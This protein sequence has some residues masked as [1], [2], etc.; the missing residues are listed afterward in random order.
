MEVTPETP[1]PA[2]SRRSSVEPS[3]QKQTPQDSNREALRRAHRTFPVRARAEAQQAVHSGS[4]QRF[5][6]QHVANHGLATVSRSTDNKVLARV[7]DSKLFERSA[8]NWTQ[9]ST[10]G[11]SINN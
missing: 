11:Q 1:I 2:G 9:I 5:D 3:E 6:K 8:L 10:L 7:Q 4:V